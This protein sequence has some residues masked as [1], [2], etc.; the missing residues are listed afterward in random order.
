MNELGAAIKKLRKEKKMT[1]AQL[2]GDRLT[3]G[4]LSLIEN[5]KAQPSI[6]SLRYI[7]DRL[8]VDVTALLHNQSLAQ[9]RTL[10]LQAEEMMKNATDVFR[11]KTQEEIL[12]EMLLLLTPVIDKIQGAYFEDV[13]LMDLWMRASR[14]LKK[15]FDLQE[16]KK[17]LEKY[18][19][20][21][22]FT[23]VIKGY[24]FLC[25]NAYEER[26]YKTVLEFLLQGEQVLNNH[27]YMVDD[28]V[29]LDLYYNLALAY[30]ALNDYKQMEVYMDKAMD[31]SKR[32]RIYYRLEDFYRL[33]FSRAVELED[34]GKSEK[35]LIKLRLLDELAQDFQM[36]T[37][38]VYANAHYANFIEKDFR[39]AIR[40]LKDFLPVLEE[41]RG[42]GSLVSPLFQVEQAY[43]HFQLGEAEH[44]IEV[45]AALY[46]PEFQQHP[47][48]LIYLYFGFA[49]RAAAYNALGN[50]EKA[51]RDILYAHNGSLTLADSKYKM[52]IIEKYEIIMK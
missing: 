24:S 17:V 35:Y 26:D 38:F 19:E 6:E 41:K 11:N 21:H 2:A 34:R 44:V 46:M 12:E 9:R 22:A 28:L 33:M 37:F 16:Y 43:A 48:D 36:H 47:F 15:G 1:L 50:H 39:K 29:K 4:M 10:L 42:K 25:W 49:I 5:G 14:Q 30:G 52:F 18:E 3:K 20:L 32:N 51:K 40:L 13:R 27:E 23:Y 8:E 7:A 31:L 45:L